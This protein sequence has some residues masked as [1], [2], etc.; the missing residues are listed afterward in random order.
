MTAEMGIRLG[1][2]T[3]L[4][5]LGGIDSRFLQWHWSKN[6]VWA[7]PSQ[8]IASVA[9][10]GYAVV[11]AAETRPLL[12][13]GGLKDWS[14]FSRSWDELP[15]DS[16]MGDGGRYRRRRY[17]EF[18]ISR[19]AIVRKPHGPHYQSRAYNPLNGGIERW[20]EPIADAM[21]LHPAL[22]AVLRT[23]YSLFDALTPVAARPYEWHVEV[24][25][26]RIVAG[27]REEGHPTP[28]GMHRDGVDW[29]L[30]LLIARERVRFGK[31]TICDLR[32]RA[33]A[34][35]TLAAPFEAAIV[36]DQRVYHEVTPVAAVDERDFGY[37]DMLIVTFSR[38]SQHCAIPQSVKS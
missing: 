5:Q 37:R 23:S 17:A 25:Q 10:K 6:P 2:G 14:G 32:K 7:L 16:Y 9:R 38:N 8:I 21:T 24:H 19:H 18:G 36:N 29:A 1:D 28:E 30:M 34:S 31:T 12:G 20:F 13:D 4:D 33:L 26:I 22:R 11:P 27:P 15:V 35:F 3:P